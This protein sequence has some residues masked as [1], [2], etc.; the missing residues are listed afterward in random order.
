M[1]CDIFEISGAITF[2]AFGFGQNEWPVDCR[3][4]LATVMEQVPEILKKIELNQY[5]FI[6]DFYEQGMERQVALSQD[7]DA[8]KLICSSRKGQSSIGW[9]IAY[10]N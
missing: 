3:I 1:I 6:L 8:I 2:K 4:D 10:A 7:K 9:R 5:D